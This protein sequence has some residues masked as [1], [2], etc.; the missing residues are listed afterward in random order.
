MW[1]CSEVWLLCPTHNRHITTHNCSQNQL[2]NKQNNLTFNFSGRRQIDT[3][4]PWEICQ[5]VFSLLSKIFNFHIFLA[6]ASCCLHTHVHRRT[7]TLIHTRPQ[8][9]PLCLFWPPFCGKLHQNISK[10][11]ASITGNQGKLEKKQKQRTAK[12]VFFFLWDAGSPL[13]IISP[14]L[15]DSVCV[16]SD[17][18]LCCHLM[19][20]FSC[21]C[22]CVFF[23]ASCFTTATACTQDRCVWLRPRP[24]SR[25]LTFAAPA[26]T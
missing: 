19:S 13:Q 9:I 23:G 15:Q 4:F 20:F 14:S 6:S 21:V 16:W 18:V 17:Q 3:I 25:W 11:S 7:R 12:K 1:L 22:V 2:F 24:Q 10:M 5:C 8:L 26:H